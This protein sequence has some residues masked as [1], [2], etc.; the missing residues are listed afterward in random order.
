[1][2]DPASLISLAIKVF[3]VPL[4]ILMAISCARISGERK[5]RPRESD[6]Y[7]LAAWG[8]SFAAVAVSHL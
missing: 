4:L 2:T 3:V 1:M 5:H 8:L 6:A 7:N